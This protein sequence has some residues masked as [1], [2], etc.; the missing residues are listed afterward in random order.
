[1]TLPCD[2][3]LGQIP[4]NTE[5]IRDIIYTE[6]TLEVSSNS[7]MQFSISHIHKQTQKYSQKQY[8]HSTVMEVII[9]KFVKSIKPIT[10]TTT[11]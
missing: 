5:I 4:S 7:V 10:S 6:W 3:D 8:S 1:M 11:T 2:L 9:T